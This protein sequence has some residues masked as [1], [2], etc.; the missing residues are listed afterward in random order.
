[1]QIVKMPIPRRGVLKGAGALGVALLSPKLPIWSLAEAA[2][3]ARAPAMFV[4]L[5]STLVG[6][7]A[8]FLEPQVI[9][10]NYSTADVFYGLERLAGTAAVDALLVAWEGFPPGDPPSLKAEKLLTTGPR[11]R[12]DDAA[13]T[14]SRLTM[15]AWL[16]GVWYGGTEVTRN[17]AAAGFITDPE[18]RQDFIVSGRAYKNSWIWRIAQAHPMGFSQFNFGSWAS[19][20]PSLADYGIT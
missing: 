10:D 8:T 12:R 16:Y 17:P 3:N 13:G 15:L 18:Y 19:A 9:Q 20:P 6:V 7:P 4:S 2:P 5:S 11:V 1:M 14:F